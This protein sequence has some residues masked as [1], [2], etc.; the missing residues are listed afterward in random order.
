MALHRTA[1]RAGEAGTG[2]PQLASGNDPDPPTSRR[3]P[4]STTSAPVSAATVAGRES[5]GPSSPSHHSPAHSRSASAKATRPQRRPSCCRV[6]TTVPV[7]VRVDAETPRRQHLRL[8]QRI[9]GR[10]RA[11]G[12]MPR[13]LADD[14]L[15]HLQDP[16]PLG[17]PDPGCAQRTMRHRTAQL[18]KDRTRRQLPR[19]E[20]SRTIRRSRRP[21]AIRPK[22][23]DIGDSA[24][25]QFNPRPCIQPR[26]DVE[27][28]NTELVA[29]PTQ[30]TGYGLPQTQIAVLVL[31][32][33]GQPGS[34]A[35]T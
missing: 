20:S 8:R 25:D 23:T 24:A 7:V 31:C 30:R 35:V 4:P 22:E 3:Q 15:D 9:R 16:L 19:T 14:P 11:H 1:D 17:T 5:S 6:A 26:R 34:S 29:Q 32:R 2:P 28:S 27:H 21:R 13:H 10:P 33:K 18:P 12:P